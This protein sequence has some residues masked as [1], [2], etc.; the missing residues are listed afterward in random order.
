MTPLIRSLA[1]V[2]DFVM[3]CTSMAGFPRLPRALAIDAMLPDQNQSVGQ[4]VERNRQASSRYAHHKFVLI[5]FLAAL[6][7]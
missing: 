1:S 4:H 3:S 5:K 7:V 6:V 2:I